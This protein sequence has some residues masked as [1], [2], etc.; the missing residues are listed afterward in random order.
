MKIGERIKKARKDKGLTQEQLASLVNVSKQVISNWERG[1]TS[2]IPTDAITSLSK[3]LDVSF[4]YLMLGEEVQ[5]QSD[6]SP[7]IKVG[8]GMLRES[9]PEYKTFNEY[10]EKE[11]LKIALSDFVND[12]TFTKKEVDEVAEIAFRQL[13]V[14]KQSYKNNNK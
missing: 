14:L 12:G 4:S 11:K 10:Q 3:A 13:L 2:T 7:E 8:V 5:M 9:A 6:V 1:Y